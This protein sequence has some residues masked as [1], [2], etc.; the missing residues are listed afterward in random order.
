MPCI[1]REFRDMCSCEDHVEFLCTSDLF[2]PH[3]GF[4]VTQL[5]FVQCKSIVKVV[6]QTREFAGSGFSISM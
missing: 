1:V 4:S 2:E 6:S 3:E 5:C